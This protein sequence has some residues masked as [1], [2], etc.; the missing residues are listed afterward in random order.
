MSSV[1]VG[2]SELLFPEENKP[3]ELGIEGVP[4]WFGDKGEGDGGKDVDKVESKGTMRVNCTEK[5]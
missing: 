3:A 5:K 1:H 2:R 4:E